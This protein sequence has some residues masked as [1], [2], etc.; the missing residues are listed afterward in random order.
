MKDG[1]KE[2]SVK[3]QPKTSENEAVEVAIR[4]KEMASIIRRARNSSPEAARAA[5]DWE[6]VLSRSIENGGQPPELEKAA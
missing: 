4:L 3:N 5:A 6:M 1:A 2:K